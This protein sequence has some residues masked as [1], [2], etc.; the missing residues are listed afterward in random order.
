MMHAN[1][2][3]PSSGSTRFAPALPGRPRAVTRSRRASRVRA[4]TQPPPSEHS[5][6]RIAAANVRDRRE[7]QT[8]LRRH[9]SVRTACATNPAREDGGNSGVR[10]DGLD[11]L[12]AELG[13]LIRRLLE[14]QP[15]LAGSD[16]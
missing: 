9:G 2:G 11:D 14:S 8:C 16:R 7:H 13:P 3:Y 12:R 10:G 15:G 6:A 1:S 5:V 4:Y